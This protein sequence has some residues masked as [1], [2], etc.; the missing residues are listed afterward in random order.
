MESFN[1]HPVQRVAECKVIKRFTSSYQLARDTSAGSLVSSPSATLKDT[2][3]SSSPPTAQ[4]TTVAH[5][6]LQTQR[7][8]Y[9]CV[10]NMTKLLYA[11]HV[12]VSINKCF[13]VDTNNTGQQNL[14]FFFLAHEEKYLILIELLTLNSNV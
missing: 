9:I 5:S 4:G 1:S 11:A 7:G 12:G 10:V 8:L 3:N 14:T 13:H 2:P 6:E